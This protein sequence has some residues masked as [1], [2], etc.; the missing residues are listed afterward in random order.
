MIDEERSPQHDTKPELRLRLLA[1]VGLGALLAGLLTIPFLALT[2]LVLSKWDALQR[3]D[4]GVADSLNR[5][6][7]VHPGVVTVLDL[8]ASL[9]SPNAFRVAAAVAVLLLWRAGSRRLAIWATV[10]MVTTAALG[11]LLKQLVQRARP[12]FPHPVASASSY[13][14]P[15]G[16]ALNSFVGVGVLLIILLPAVGRSWKIVLSVVGAGLVLLTGFDRIGLGVHYVSDVV[17][18]WFVGAAVI[19]GTATAFNTWRG[20]RAGAVSPPAGPAVSRMT[21]DTLPD[22]VEAPAST[23]RGGAPRRPRR[24]IGVGADVDVR[25]DQDRVTE[26]GGPTWSTGTVLGMA[27]LAFALLYGVLVVVGLL[28]T[29]V[30][31]SVP[32]F[33]DEDAVNRSLAAGRTAAETDVSRVFSTLGSTPFVIGVMIVVAIVFRL[34]FRRWRES[35]F[36]VL[37]VSAPALIFLLLTLTLPRERPTSVKHLDPSPPTSSFPSG[38]TGASTALFVGI[39]VVIAWHTRHLWARRSVIV[40][41]VAVPVMGAIARLYRGMHHL[42]DVLAALGN[43]ASCVAISARTLLFRALPAPLARRLDG[44]GA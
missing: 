41:L 2:L 40:V 43:G 29:K 23:R 8:L 22:V 30:L 3:L 5:W 17:A 42:S 31:G 1:R 14:F 38:H 6:A 28:L 21:W 32:P 39:A 9:L 44:A 20:Y 11:V 10:T 15:S 16:H 34:V 7:L 26:D 25:T 13:S 19:A 4:I 36:L 37:A 33:S 18:G 35:T 12:S 27:L 24:S